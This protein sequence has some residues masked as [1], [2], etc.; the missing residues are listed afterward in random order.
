MNAYRTHYFRRTKGTHLGR[1]TGATGGPVL[2]TAVFAHCFTCTKDS[3]AATRIS[4]RLAA[5][6]IA[7]LR[8]DFSGI[9]QSEGAFQ[10]T[11]FSSNIDDL[12][13]ASDYMASRG[14]PPSLLVGHSL[15]GTAVLAAAHRLPYVHAIATIGAPA[16]PL[17]VTRQFEDALPEI[18]E[19]GEAEVPDWRP[20]DSHRRG[21]CARRGVD[22]DPGPDQQA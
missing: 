8:F 5:A 15:G 9:G 3:L 14:M 18:R 21:F 2:A 11:S 6:G 19:A 4:R 13:A 7:V 17:S 20:C 12:V 10:E 22:L 16:S 1:A